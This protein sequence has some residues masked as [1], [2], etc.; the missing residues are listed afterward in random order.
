M[1]LIFVFFRFVKIVWF[2]KWENV[3]IK[4]WYERSRRHGSI[5]SA[6]VGTISIADFSGLARVEYCLTKRAFDASNP[7]KFAMCAISELLLARSESAIDLINLNFIY[8]KQTLER[9]NR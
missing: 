3:P 7:G 5:N 9:I 2:T 8:S 4:L 1:G 6:A